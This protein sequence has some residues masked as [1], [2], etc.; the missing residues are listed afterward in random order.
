L[1]DDGGE[2][3]YR[4]S[5]CGK[6]CRAIE[7]VFAELTEESGEDSEDFE[8]EENDGEDRPSKSSHI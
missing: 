6:S 5:H 1:I 2:I 7:D 8:F 4:V 3:K